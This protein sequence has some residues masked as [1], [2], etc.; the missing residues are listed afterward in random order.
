MD[1]KSLMTFSESLY[2][3]CVYENYSRNIHKGKIEN[4]LNARNSR[5]VKQIMK[6]SYKEKKYRS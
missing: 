1:R 2:M 5:L 3:R 6:H 4:H